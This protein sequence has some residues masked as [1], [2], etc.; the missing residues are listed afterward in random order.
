MGKMAEIDYENQQTDKDG[1]EGVVDLKK[2]MKPKKK[3]IIQITTK[4]K[5]VKKVKPKE[6]KKKTEPSINS[7]VELNAKRIDTLSKG[8]DDMKI[9]LDRVATRMGLE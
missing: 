7:K 3:E 8:M 1:T 9:L 4:K 5:E 2:E 6:A